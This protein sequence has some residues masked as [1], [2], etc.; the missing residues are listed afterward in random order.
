M[1]EHLDIYVLMLIQ[2]NGIQ[3]VC[4]NF[5]SIRDNYY[6]TKYGG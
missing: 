1:Y 6:M 3:Y 5:L 2:I 4:D